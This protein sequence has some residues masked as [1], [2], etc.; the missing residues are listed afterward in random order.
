[1]KHRYTSKT[2]IDA[3]AELDR[4][5]AWLRDIGINYSPTRV[6]KYRKLFASIAKHQQSKTLPAFLERETFESWVNAVHEVAEISRIFEGLSA[7]DNKN[8]IQRLQK[9]LKGHDKYVLEDNDSSGRDFSFELSVA[10][11]FVRSGYTVD[12]SHDADVAVDI[13]QFKFYVECKRLKSENQI[14]KRISEGLNQLTTRYEGSQNP[15]LTRGILALSIGKTINA[16]LGLLVAENPMT[17]ADVAFRHNAGFIE[18]YKSCWQMNVDQRTLGVAIIL[19]A[20]GVIEAEKK[21]VTCHEITIINSVP[22]DTDNYAL[23]HRVAHQVFGWGSPPTTV[24][25]LKE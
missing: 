17:L 12:F 2:Y 1:V 24:G 21:L 13:E 5:C 3:S 14:E 19:D 18:T 9:S 22:V 25:P 10:A 6:G 11:K 20:P 7:Q 8:L 4:A 16:D 15:S 23:L